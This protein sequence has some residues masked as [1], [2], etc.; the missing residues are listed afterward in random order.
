MFATSCSNTVIHET[1]C[2][3]SCASKKEA[4]TGCDPLTFTACFTFIATE[5]LAYILN[6]GRNFPLGRI[7]Y[8]EY[9]IDIEL[10]E[11]ACDAARL[12]HGV[13]QQL[14]HSSMLALQENSHV[15]FALV[16]LTE[17]AG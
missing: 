6:T 13:S 5:A 4:A 14:L 3:V 17:E 8:M 15:N 9:V 1:D 10:F 11:Y 16:L 2:D 12:P 7:F